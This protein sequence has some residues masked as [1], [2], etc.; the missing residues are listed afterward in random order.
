MKKTAKKVLS[1]LIALMMSAT[2]FVGCAPTNE[3]TNIKAP[4]TV[5]TDVVS[6][7][8]TE[9]EEV[10]LTSG[11]ELP[12]Q[13][14]K[15]DNIYV[16]ESDLYY[17]NNEKNDG[18]DPGI[19]YT[20]EEDL[21]F[22]YD[23]LFAKEK[24]F[25]PDA[26]DD[27]VWEVVGQ[28]YGTWDYWT[29][30]YLG[31]FYTVHSS[32][33]ATLSPQ[34]KQKYPEAAYGGYLL[35][36]SPDLNNWKIEG[37]IEG[38]AV[39]GYTNGW[40]QSNIRNWAPEIAKDPFSGLY[41][42]VGS[43]NTKSGNTTTDYHPFTTLG[44]DSY[45]EQ[46]D[47]MIPYLAISNNPIGPYHYV[48]SEEYY[49]Y[50]A[51]FNADGTPFTIEID[52]EKWAVYREDLKFEQ[53]NEYGGY[54]PLSKVNKNDAILNQNGLDVTR[55][56]C[57]LNA[58]Y[59]NPEIWEAYQHWNSD[60][61]GLFP[62]IDTNFLVDS[63]GDVYLYFSAHVGSVI[64]GNHVWVI[65][66]LDLVTPDWERMTHVTT[67]SYSTIYYDPDVS[68]YYDAF[69]EDGRYFY[70]P[71]YVEHKGGKDNLKYSING[72]PGYYMGFASEGGINEGTHVVEKDGWY[73]MTYSPFGYGSR[74]YS[75]YTAIADNPLGPFIK[76]PQYYPV[77]GL[78]QSETQ[79]YMAGA[80]HHSFVTV[81]DEMWVVYHYFYNPVDNVWADGGFLGRCI[82]VDRIGW[83]DY[84]QNT[85]EK[86]MNE[87]IEK[88]IDFAKTNKRS[89][90]KQIFGTD[91]EAME[92][93]I[94]ECYD[95]GNHRYYE[96]RV[97]YTDVFPI[98][99]GSGPTYSLQPLP[100]VSTGY[101]NVAQNA[102]VTILE[103][104]A[105]TA[106][107][108]NDGMFTYQPW[109]EPYEVVGN[110]NTR[111]LKVKLS[112]DK[113]QTIRNIMVYNS[114]N[115]AYAF[116]N[117][118][119]IVFKLS[120]K[121]SWYPEGKEYNGYAHI[122]DLKPDSQGWDDS[123]FV[124]RKGGSAMATFNEI[125][126]TEVIITIDAADKVGEIILTSANRYTVKLSEIY[127]MGNPADQ[128]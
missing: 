9:T 59:Y 18:C 102:T 23:K 100:E 1:G 7:E 10:G 11:F 31:K 13:D 68:C 117:V 84:D 17:H 30:K 62:G 71:H 32:H 108:A 86:V 34:T 64:A 58:G 15:V 12:Y 33:T 87:Q 112:W 27:E 38:Y 24:Q 20:G 8:V 125:T 95:T 19:M 73:Y 96:K 22:S 104:E 74:K 36:T 103:G 119:S 49:S 40:D 6:S 106:K 127:I 39:E 97:E 43:A 51:K 98:L 56:K 65:P 123:N 21:R 90:L 42:I 107:Y 76:L 82:G 101:D 116:N 44:Y 118:E 37:E 115:Y 111:Q 25:L 122:K 53:G 114:R 109:S 89:E 81:G 93:W 124:M 78:D 26:T 92:E 126:V 45:H 66:M 2:L 3:V 28:K 63:Q 121:P 54:V 75:L 79:D 48:T 94:R 16:Y 110:A 35:R 14:G 47:N 99:Y 60:Y 61:R 113:P 91:Y 88:D 67:P 105:D 57:F 46:Y 4:S 69:T 72:V 55:D 52:G 5:S 70:Q 50:I 120:E 80:G 85:F 83:Y 41:V 77:F 29:E 128:E